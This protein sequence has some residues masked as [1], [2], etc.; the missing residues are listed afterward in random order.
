MGRHNQFISSPRRFVAYRRSEDGTPAKSKALRRA[1]QIPDSGRPRP[2]Q[3]EQTS[4]SQF[5]HRKMIQSP[6]R[7][8]LPT[9]WATHSLAKAIA[10]VR[11]CPSVSVRVNLT[12]SH[13]IKPPQLYSYRR[14]FDQFR[15]IS[16]N[17][18]LLFFQAAPGIT[19]RNSTYFYLFQPIFM[20]GGVTL[21]CRAVAQRRR[22][23]VNQSKSNLLI[24]PHP[25]TYLPRRSLLRRQVTR[26]RTGREEFPQNVR[27]AKTCKKIQVNV[28]K[29]RS[30]NGGRGAIPHSALRTPPENPSTL[31]PCNPSTLGTK[32]FWA[33]E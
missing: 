23:K 9:P 17:F 25:V 29:C 33:T 28:G 7:F 11:P 6:G 20:G 30:F 31:A 32:L 1:D 27:F 5:F 24:E 22:I 13:Q 19:A 21:A 26:R 4:R 8:F 16:T 12:P 18:D 3:C 10:R 2:Q 15:V 14:P